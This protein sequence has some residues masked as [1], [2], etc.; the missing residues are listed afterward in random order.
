MNKHAN[1]GHTVSQEIRSHLVMFTA[2]YGDLKKLDRLAAQRSGQSHYW[3]EDPCMHGHM[4]WRT[5][6]GGRC[7][8][9]ER[10]YNQQAR[11]KR[12]RAKDESR[13]L[14]IDALLEERRLQRELKEMEL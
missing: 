8:M 1:K 13:M 11:N 12:L 4:F 5:V 14:D 6:G 7:V 3:P 10:R 2:K 9:C